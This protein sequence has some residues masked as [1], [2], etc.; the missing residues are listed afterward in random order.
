MLGSFT[1]PEIACR[2]SFKATTAGR[3]PSRPTTARTAGPQEDA[4]SERRVC[5]VSPPAK[6]KLEDRLAAAAR[7]K[8]AQASKE[9]KEK[10]LQ[11]ERKRKAAL[12]LQTLKQPVPEAEGGKAEEGPL[13]AEVSLGSA[14]SLRGRTIAR[15]RERGLLAVRPP[16]LRGAP[17]RRLLSLPLCGR[18]GGLALVPSRCGLEA[19]GREALSLAQHLPL[20][21]SHGRASH[22]GMSLLARGPA[23]PAPS[24]AVWPGLEW[25]PVRMRRH[26]CR[27]HALPAPPAPHAPLGCRADVCVSGP[28]SEGAR[29]ARG[30]LVGWFSRGGQPSGFARSALSGR[31]CRLGCLE[32]LRSQ[33]GCPV[34]G[35]G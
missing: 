8:L 30:L 28:H 20:S 24:S 11:A 4:R 17:P 22:G 14:S 27:P 5:A 18:A 15:G 6:Q 33:T 25:P 23:F 34:P 9:S 13:S 7:E 12:F 29:A 10:Q 35:K 32:P 26:G 2:G 21:A 1:R 31:P 3:G 16:S 19:A